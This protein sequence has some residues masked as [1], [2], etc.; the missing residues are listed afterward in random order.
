M[1]SVVKMKIKD[2]F[3]CILGLVSHNNVSKVLEN[4]TVEIIR[5]L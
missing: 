1:T 2:D 4:E 5:L 3:V